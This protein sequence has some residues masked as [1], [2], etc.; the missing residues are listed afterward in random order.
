MQNNQFLSK[1]SL[2]GAAWLGK[3]YYIE[4]GVKTNGGYKKKPYTTVNCLGELTTT[5]RNNLIENFTNLEK[6]GFKESR[7]EMH[8]LELPDYAESLSFGVK[9]YQGAYALS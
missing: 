6:S 9:P 5:Y 2:K 7:T 4:G 8:Y 3:H 1:I